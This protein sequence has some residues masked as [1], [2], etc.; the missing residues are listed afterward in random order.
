M[1]RGL[2]VGLQPDNI[3]RVGL[4]SD[5]QGKEKERTAWPAIR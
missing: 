1:K 5:L 3:R 2:S 4:K